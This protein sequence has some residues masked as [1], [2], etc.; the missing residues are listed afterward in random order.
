MAV[1]ELDYKESWAAKNCCFWIV[2]LE[3]T[4]ESPLDYKEIQPVHSK[5]DRSW[6]FIG[7][8]DFE[9][10]TL[11]LW[12]SD[13]KSC[14]IWKDPDA[15]KDWRREEK[16]MTEDEIVGWHHRLN[17]HGFGWTQPHVGRELVM[18]RE[19]WCAAVHG[20]TKSWTRLSDWTD[21]ECFI[22]HMV[23]KTHLFYP[24][25]CWWTLGL[26]SIFWKLKTVLLWVLGFMY[27]SEL[28]IL[29]F[30]HISRSGI[31]GS[32]DNSILVF[33]GGSIIFSI[34][35]VPLYTHT[36]SAQEFPFVHILSKSCYL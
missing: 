7:R 32:Y 4:L 13:G 22:I 1:G 26:F 10:E 27:L 36:T 33:W 9:A 12:P 35:T 29:F 24:F 8:T 17:G 34:V 25:I 6:V 11:V 21:T 28:V 30:L 15:G 5:R 14:L 18:D 3:K 20:V 31:A 19:A 23:Y 2:V 16:G